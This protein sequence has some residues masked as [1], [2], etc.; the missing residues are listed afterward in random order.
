MLKTALV[1]LALLVAP[2]HAES[3]NQRERHQ[4]SR[5]YRGV[6]SGQ[7]NPYETRRVT[8]NLAHI[9]NAENRFRQSGCGYTARERYATQ[10]M[11]NRSSN[12]IYRL[13]HN[14]R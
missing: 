11:L 6:Q 3:V 4:G 14:G 12:R 5:V 13:K 7:L 1:L 10:A 2:V 9:Q 8:R